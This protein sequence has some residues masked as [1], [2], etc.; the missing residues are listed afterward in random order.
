MAKLVN[1]LLHG[2]FGY[3]L[4]DDYIYA[5]T[6]CVCGHIYKTSTGSGKSLDDADDFNRGDYALL[7]V[8]TGSAFPF[9]VDRYP[10]VPIALDAKHQI[11]EFGKRY[12]MFR[13]PYP[14]SLHRVCAL[15]KYQVGS[16]YAGRDA[17]PLNGSELDPSCVGQVASLHMFTYAEDGTTLQLA[18]LD[19]VSGEIGRG[20][21]IL[22]G[23]TFTRV[24]RDRVTNFHIWCTTP[25]MDMK[26]DG[27]TAEGHLRRGFAS[28]VDMFP[29][30]EVTIE[31]P[32]G[33]T[34]KAVSD[35]APLGVSSVDVD[36]TR[37]RE[38]GRNGIS[39]YFG[40]VNC[41]Y[42]NILFVP[43]ESATRKLAKPMSRKTTKGRN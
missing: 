24:G 12:S 5:Y 37:D 38:P 43:T 33:F 23:K 17:G 21:P 27:Y 4:A 20:A 36:P 31:F 14:E 10:Q 29:R 13:L 3:V 42:A 28:L 16:I 2:I 19:P 41:H 25:P 6:P 26:K 34:P 1:V 39:P 35:Q 7:G 9:P 15:D 18:S 8:L 32:D 30:I 11:D 22:V 40:H